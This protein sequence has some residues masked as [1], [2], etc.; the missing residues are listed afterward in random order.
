M[1][2]STYLLV[3]LKEEE[4]LIGKLKRDFFD[5]GEYIRTTLSNIVKINLVPTERGM[6]P[7]PSYYP[8]LFI[9]S[10]VKKDYLDTLVIDINEKNYLFVDEENINSD[11]LDLYRKEI[12]KR[13]GVPEIDIM[14]GIPS[15]IRPIR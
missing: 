13:D 12:N 7:V 3:S 8:S 1:E 14:K 4:I 5:N 11:L 6:A 10:F 15:N 2:P 9:G